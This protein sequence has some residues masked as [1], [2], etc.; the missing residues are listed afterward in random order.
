MTPDP[1]IRAAFYLSPTLDALWRWS[2]DGET[3]VW[4]DDRT[5]AFR[6]EVE[7]VLRRL[8]PGGLPP[9]GAVALL[10]GACRGDAWADSHGRQTIAG[11]GQLFGAN[12]AAGDKAGAVKN[13]AKTLISHRMRAEVNALLTGFDAVGRLPAE[14]RESPDAKALVAEVVFEAS[15]NRSSADDAAL[16]IRALDEGVSPD[17]LRCQLSDQDALP[18]FAQQVDGMS[19][20]LQRV[21]AETLAR[22]AKTGLDESVQAPDEDLAP[23]ERVRQ[24]L[25]ELRDDPEM[26]GVARLA[27]DL[28]AAVSIPRPLRLRDELAVGGVS[29][30]TNRGPLDRLLVSELAHDDLTLAVRVAVNEAL[31]LRRESP[32][33]EPPHR[34]AI[35]L[36]AGI[37]MWGVPR[38]FAAAVALALAATNDPRAELAVF[39]AAA[40]GRVESVDLTSRRGLEAHLGVLEVAAHPGGSLA[41]FFERLRD[42]ENGD[43]PADAVL[44]THPD[45]LA[46]PAFVAV[47]ARALPNVEATVYVATVDRD[48]GFRLV[49]M[50][51]AGQRVVREAELRLDAVLNPA[52][53]R[54]GGESRRSVPLVDK[55]VDLSLPAIHYADPFPIRLPHVADPRRASVS[56]ANGLVAA[57]DDGRLLHWPDG[58]HGARQ[59]TGMLPRGVVRHVHVDD[60]N[61]AAYVLITRARLQE[62][63]L[64]VADLERCQANVTRLASNDPAFSAAVIRHAAVHLIYKDRVDTFNDAGQPLGRVKT[65]DFQW[66]GGRFFHHP[67]AGEYC[68]PEA[69][70]GG[71]LQ[72]MPRPSN[73]EYVVRWFDSPGVDGPVALMSDGSLVTGTGTTLHPRAAEREARHF[74][75]V[76]HDGA[77][78]LFMIDGKGKH[79]DVQSGSSTQRQITGEGPLTPQIWWSTCGSVTPRTKFRSVFV[80]GESRLCLVNRKGVQGC[81]IETR[82]EPANLGFLEGGVLRPPRRAERTFQEQRRSHVSRVK[83]HVASWDDGSRVFLD[84]RGI[85]HL[86]S[87]DRSIPEV[88][89]ALTNDRVAA[90]S[91]DG[92]VC[93]PPWLIGDNVV[94]SE[95]AYFMRLI[96]QFVERLR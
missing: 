82:D 60:Q 34:R 76:S 90:W 58:R 30:L 74:V 59:I 94:V 17:M 31:Y 48:G 93:G 25:A 45:A 39:R 9:F 8:A 50:T 95:P 87:G 12:P 75:G 51:R 5:I 6:A 23:P 37:R 73:L 61:P 69:A 71:V 36:D 83:M 57:T 2:V 44:I 54:Q 38:V 11:Y 84:G 96:R 14:L 64:V 15:K 28:M 53:P 27:S 43:E 68:L 49:S 70:M 10:L 55:G 89:I 26:A 46:D 88:S 56:K 19:I 33:R 79:F 66:K 81:V 32:P 24:L 1:H 52:S 92:R 35:L 20:G 86:K 77:S 29:D 13:T 41:A 42:E 72:R 78:L 40:E 4:A 62:I 67:G 80:D 47:A 16:V 18:Q 3:L 85:V 91:S 63:D 65:T 7:T 21:D 22:R